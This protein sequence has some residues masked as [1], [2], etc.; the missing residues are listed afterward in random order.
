MLLLSISLFTFASSLCYCLHK[1]TV[2]TELPSVFIRGPS[3]ELDH[4]NDANE[5]V[6]EFA[7]KEKKEKIKK[8]LKE[9]KYGKLIKK[10]GKEVESSCCICVDDFKDS[11]TV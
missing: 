3:R 8:Q 2:G 9:W 1:V 6:R 5:A 7:K 10:S 11:T 4:S